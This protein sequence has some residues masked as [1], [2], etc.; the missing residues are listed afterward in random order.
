MQQQLMKSS[1]KNSVI[2]LA[3][4]LFTVMAGLSN[5]SIANAG[6]VENQWKLFRALKIQN[7]IVPAH[8]LINTAI[9]EN[10]IGPGK[11]VRVIVDIIGNAKHENLLTIRAN[12]RGVMYTEKT[13]TS[14]HTI[15]CP[16][17]QKVGMM[18]WTILS[19]CATSIIDM[20]NLNFGMLLCGNIPKKLKNLLLSFIRPGQNN[21]LVLVS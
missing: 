13:S 16:T 4:V 6:N 17:Q 19:Y 2:V 1:T 21:Q 15:L 18:A 14:M 20:L 12:L 7:I 3:V 10:E 5:V 11:V 9:V 8:V